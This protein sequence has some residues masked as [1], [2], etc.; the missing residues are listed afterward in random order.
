MLQA[1]VERVQPAGTVRQQEG[2]IMRFEG[3]VAFVAGAG[4]GMGQAMAQALLARGAHV[5]MADLKPTPTELGPSGERHL[6]LQGDLTE[7]AFV[8]SAIGGWAERHG[9][10]DYLVNTA[11]VLWFGRDKSC[12]DMDMDVWDRVMAINLKSFALT[13]RHAV[14]AMQRAGGGAMV[15][16]SSI[17]ALRGD[18]RPQDAY[19][20]SKAAVIRLS[21][22]VAIQFAR[23][24]IRSNVILP[25][26]VHT[27]MQA[28]WDGNA[29]AVDRLAQVVPLGRIGK[30][31]DMVSA[32][33]FLLSDEAAFITGTELVVDGGLTARP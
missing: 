33:L 26:P 29:D 21:K 10:L 19:G 31:E 4:G 30:V 2:P 1:E 18:D 20:A 17:D 6:Y 28:R 9:R 14:P 32:C 16:L 27:P 8:A 5:G 23:Q 7:E 25:G 22:S 3:K 12:T 11:G 15:H 13:I 24:K